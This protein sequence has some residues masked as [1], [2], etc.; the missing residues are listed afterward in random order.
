MVKPSEKW[1]QLAKR[2]EKQR[3]EL[4]IRSFRDFLYLTHLIEKYLDAQLS[5]D[6]INR[7]QR[8]IILFILLKCEFM[9]PTELSRISLHSVDR[10]NKSI[11]ALDKMGITKSYHSNK[12]RRIRKVTLTEK[13]LDLVEMI[14]PI[15]HRVFSQAMHSFTKED[16]RVFRSLLKQQKEQ[17]L[18]IMKNDG[19]KS[20]KTRVRL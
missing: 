11:D 19:T 3:K 4:K 6:S 8:M 7:T 10:I 9:T 20:K 18:Q 13:G 5:N 17:I 2:L 14:L 16:M 1:Y 12:D 15:E